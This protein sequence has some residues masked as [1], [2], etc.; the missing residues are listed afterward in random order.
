MGEEEEDDSD[1][2]LREEEEEG[3]IG[4]AEYPLV[5]AH[6]VSAQP[7]VEGHG[8]RHDLKCDHSME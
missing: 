7:N 6:T 5:P 2:K 1:D 3:R 8:I 4:R